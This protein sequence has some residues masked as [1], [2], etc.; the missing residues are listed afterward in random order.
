M[1]REA[2]N[3]P[4][5]W[6]ANFEMN[7]AEKITRFKELVHFSGQTA[8][9]PDEKA[10]MGLDVMHPGDIGGQLGFILEMVDNLL[11]R[12]GLARENIIHVRF[13]TTDMTGFLESYGTYANW[14]REAGIRPPQSAIGI[15]Q[16]VVPELKLEMEVTAAR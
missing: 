3:P 8:L 15:N 2:I 11:E 9:Y 14:I 1:N 12:A 4:N 10:E 16:L 13:F 7:Q 5:D 6:G